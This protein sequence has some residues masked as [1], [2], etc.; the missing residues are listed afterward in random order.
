MFTDMAEQIFR[1][2][3]SLLLFTG[4]DT[5]QFAFSI[6][7]QLYHTDGT[8]IPAIDQGKH[9]PLV[10]IAINYIFARIS[11]EKHLH[12]FIFVSPDL[13]NLHAS[14]SLKNLFSL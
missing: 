11:H 4:N 7:Q 6:L 5:F 8:D 12:I 10:K 3:L 1:I 13:L 2:T 9:F 14:A